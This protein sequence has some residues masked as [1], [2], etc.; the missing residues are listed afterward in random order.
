MLLTDSVVQRVLQVKETD[1]KQLKKREDPLA[2]NGK[3]FYT[4][5]FSHCCQYLRN[6]STC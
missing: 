4:F 3:T 2:Y 1:K 6:I 5:T